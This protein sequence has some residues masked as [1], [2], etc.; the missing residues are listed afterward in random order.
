MLRCLRHHTWLG[1]LALVL[2]VLTGV[3]VGRASAATLTVC[4]GSCKY[5]TIKDAL[6]A[7]KSGDKITIGPGIY[8]G[9][10]TI[11]KSVSMHGA[12]AGQTT[13][14]GSVT[15]VSELPLISVDLA[16]L[17]IALENAIESAI[18]DHGGSLTLRNVFV[19]GG[20]NDFGG[21]I[22]NDGTLTITDSTISGNTATYEG[23]GIYNLGKLTL[24]DS[25][26]SDNKAGVDGGGIF[27]NGGTV[28]L[29][30][31]ILSGNTPNDCKE[32]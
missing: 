22:R 25:T 7:A 9:D 32:C 19:S 1:L 30:D 10:L 28:T 26:V 16:D 2:L 5:T 6:A 31:S 15:L 21:G 23:G 4:A 24:K 12:G 20:N 14:D 3:A 8:S 17:T 29:K 27:N 13:M 18:V 11:D